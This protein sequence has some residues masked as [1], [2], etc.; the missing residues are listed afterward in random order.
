MFRGEDF[1]LWTM[2]GARR[3]VAAAEALVASQRLTYA[4]TARMAA[5]REL[6]T[7]VRD[8]HRKHADLEDVKEYDVALEE[9]QQRE[10]AAARELQDALERARGREW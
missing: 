10:E 4:T 7:V 6:L 8:Y 3:A 9:R 2:R 5:E 1:I